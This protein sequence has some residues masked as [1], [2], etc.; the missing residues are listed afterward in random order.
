MIS[1]IVPTI[2]RPTLYRALQSITQQRGDDDEVLVVGESP[3][4]AAVAAV[5]GCTFVECA[6][7]HNWGAAERT[8]GIARARGQHLA[9][10]DDDDIYLPGARQLM[11]DARATVRDKPILFR[12]VWNDRVLW[13]EPALRV[14]NVSS[15][16]MLIPNDKTKLGRWGTRYEGDFDFLASMRWA[17]SEIVWCADVIAHLRPAAPPVLQHL[18]QGWL[19]H[20]PQLLDLL[21]AHRPH[22]CVELGTWRG[23]S[24]IAFAHE[25]RQ[26]GGVLTCVD[27]WMGAVAY[28]GTVTG[29]PQMLFECATNLVAAHVAPSVRLVPALTTAAAAAWTDGPIDFLYVDADHSYEST[30]ADLDAWWPHVRVGG[31]VAGDDYDNVMYPGVKR[32][33][34]EFEQRHGQCF[35]RVETPNTDPPGM[36]LVFGIKKAEASMLRETPTPD[37]DPEPDPDPDPTPEL[38]R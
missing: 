6:R 16:M 30:A 36:K 29:A 24:A 33:W 4:A 12:M 7:G 11:E 18:P 2:G 9:F 5:A 27:T 34:D 28:G 19:H 20:G 10:M 17:P 38:S 37:P 35:A 31:I 23:A 14:G 21:H 15:Q 8:A 32:A 3:S 1:F 25:L 26:W 13:S 22:R